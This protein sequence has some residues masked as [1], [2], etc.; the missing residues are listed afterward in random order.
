MQKV[1]KELWAGQQLVLA[2][3]S[4]LVATLIASVALLPALSVSSLHFLHYLE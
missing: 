1:H 3:V 2:L 4:G